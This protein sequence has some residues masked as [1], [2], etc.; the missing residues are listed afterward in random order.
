MG[1]SDGLDGGKSVSANNFLSGSH[2][3]SPSP[4]RRQGRTLERAAASSSNARGWRW[5]AGMVGAVRLLFQVRSV[6]LQRLHWISYQ[7]DSPLLDPL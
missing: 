7:I 3:P 4:M 1:A 2:F 5:R 6:L